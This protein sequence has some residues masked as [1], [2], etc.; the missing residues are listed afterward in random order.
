LDFLR[1]HW[2]VLLPRDPGDRLKAFYDAVM[3]YLAE[4]PMRPQS[5][6][7]CGMMEGARGLAG[8]RV[9]AWMGCSNP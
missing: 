9:A 2:S 1:K 5:N 7:C 8:T 3:A 4:H 6:R